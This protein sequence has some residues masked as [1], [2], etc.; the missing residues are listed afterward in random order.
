MKPEPSGKNG[1]NEMPC[2]MHASS[3]GCDVRSTRLYAF[4]TVHDL[5]AVQRDSQMVERDAAQPDPGDEALVAGG[6]H[7]RQLTVE[8]FAIDVGRGVGIVAAVDAQ[9]DRGQLGRRRASR[10]FSS[11]SAAVRRVAGPVDPRALVVAPR[12]DLA[13]QREVV[14]DT[15]AAPRGSVRWRRRGRRTG[16]VSMWS[17]PSSTARLSTASAWS[18]SRGGPNTPGPGNCMAPNPTR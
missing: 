8:Q 14:P 11:M 2:S 1:T 12:T 3:T 17:T 7:G 15:G 13:H 5:G 18:W 9:V 16:T 10:R 4:W 6:D